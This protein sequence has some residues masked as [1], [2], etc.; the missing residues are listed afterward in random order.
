[1]SYEPVLELTRGNQLE[2]LHYGAIVVVD[3]KGIV[4]AS[5][6]DESTVT[7][8]RSSAK[9][10]QAI[11]LIES[12]ASN[13]F[14]FTPQQIAVICAS[15]SGTDSHVAVVRSIQESIG[16]EERDLRCG[17]HKPYDQETAKRLKENGIEPNQNYHNCSGKHSGMLALARYLDEPI[18][19]YL[20]PHQTVQVRIMDVVVEM[21]DLP[22]EEIHVGIDGCSAPNFALPL[23]ATALGYAKLADPKHLQEQRATACKVIWSAMTSHPEMVAGPGRFDTVLMEVGAGKILAKGGAEGYQ[24][25]A[26]APGVLWQDSPGLGVALKIADGDQG[27]RARSVVAL[28]VLKQLGALN[29]FQLGR[30]EEFGPREITNWRSLVVGEIRPCFQLN[31]LK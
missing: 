9:P 19:G 2:S 5:W 24:G 28:E 1:M 15:H 23:H 27:G 8:L 13:H 4:R 6:G 18:E 29:D 10:F 25:I 20:D 17:V 30:L 14:A 21:F 31:L 7:F 16:V 22:E 3:A 12:G 26:I 11:P